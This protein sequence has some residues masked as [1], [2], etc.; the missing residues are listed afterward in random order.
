MLDI[1]KLERRWLK[2]KIKKALP[3]GVVITSI[4]I[5]G[6]TI[7]LLL[8]NKLSTALPTAVKKEIIQSKTTPTIP[9]KH[10]E[11]SM[12]LEPSMDFIQSMN[13]IAVSTTL[14]PVVI[15]PVTSVKKTLIP[16][17][18]PPIPPLAKE[19]LSKTQPALMLKAPQ[20][21]IKG[22]LTSIKRNDATFD[23][24][25]IEERFKE[26]SNPNLGLY[27]ARYHYDH[28]N[29]TQAYN[30][31]LKT[32]AINNT[33]DDSWLIF[34]KSLVKLGKVDQAKKT[35]QL[36]ITNSN[37]DSAKNLLDTLNKENSQ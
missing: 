13:P 18:I 7:P 28:G 22:K 30:Y 4:L 20:P 25:E 11:D 14:I 10:N 33:M 3:Y 31:A 1:S 34:A 27:I 21:V 15:A 6:I 19:P 12:I 8:S 37:S 5:L 17:T 26:N 23:I 9:S 2:Y 16:S 24:H 29:Y 36:Y 35:L 32:N